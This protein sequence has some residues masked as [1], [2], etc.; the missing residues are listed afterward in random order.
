MPTVATYVTEK[1]SFLVKGAV[2][3]LTLC[4]IRGG[5]G[6]GGGERQCG[7]GKGSGLVFEK[8]KLE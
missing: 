8:V 6:R 5:F 1:H 3:H 7:P 2:T 4:I